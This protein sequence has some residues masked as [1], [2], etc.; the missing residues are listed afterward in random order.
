MLAGRGEVRPRSAPGRA[1]SPRPR[2]AQKCVGADGGQPDADV[3]DRV[4]VEPDGGA[5]G[6]DRPVADP[7]LDLLV[8]AAGARADRH[9]DLGEHLGRPD[10]GLVRAEVELSRRTRALAARRRG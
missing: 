3:G 4:A 1:G 9:P 5:G 10:H 8:G 7:P 6:G 2:G